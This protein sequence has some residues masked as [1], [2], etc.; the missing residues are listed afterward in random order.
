MKRRK[1]CVIALVMILFS[2]ILVLPVL[3]AEEKEERKGTIIISAKEKVCFEY[4]KIGEIVDGEF[5]LNEEYKKSGVNLNYLNYSKELERAVKKLNPYMKPEGRVLTDKNGEAK[6]EHLSS[7]IYLLRH[8]GNPILVP[9]PL[10]DEKLQ[11]YIY[12]VTVI[13]KLEEP[14]APQTNLYSHT[15]VYLVIIM[16]L[17]M[18]A[19]MFS[20]K[21][22]KEYQPYRV[23]GENRRNLRAHAIEMKEAGPYDR[24][25][26]FTRLREE[27]PDISAWIYIPGT[28]IDDPVLIGKTDTEYLHKNFKGE[29]SAL[30]S[31]FGFSDMSRD[32][33]EAHICLFGHNMSTNQMFGE[34][35]KYRN[36]EFT[37][38]HLEVYLYTPDS[39][40]KYQVFSIYDCE[41]R[42][43]TFAHKMKYNSEEF[44]SLLERM[45]ENNRIEKIS[46]LD[47]PENRQILTLASCSD[48]RETANRFTVNCI[49]E[50]EQK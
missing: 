28:Q 38:E 47:L 46:A 23:S 24:R 41:K 10:W 5:L 21:A 8:E 43:Y 15:R 49:L 39:V 45:Q 7:G 11:D 18:C 12:D 17:L 6:I 9:M 44:L 27:N 4:A 3:A 20:Y 2:G 19:A 35:K 42:D 50:E 13:P 37:E 32:F 31:I 29:K 22:R 16:A 36:R 25:I 48:Y 1:K 14:V 40:K 30:G 34:L 26:D 33:T